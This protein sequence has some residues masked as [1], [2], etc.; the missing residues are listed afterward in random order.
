MRG[1]GSRYVNADWMLP[2]FFTSRSIPIEYAY[3]K[4]V[5]YAI[6]PYP[7]QGQQGSIKPEPDQGTPAASSNLPLSP[8]TVAATVAPVPALHYTILNPTWE[9]DT[10]ALRRFDDAFD[11]AITNIKRIAALRARSDNIR[12]FLRQK[13]V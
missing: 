1:A 8:A 6:Q 7:Q 11:I 4:Q 9:T 5:P 2:A 10:E 13:D 12:A 3:F